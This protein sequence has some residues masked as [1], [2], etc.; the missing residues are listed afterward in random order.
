MWWSGWCVIRISKLDPK[1]KNH[2]ISTCVDNRILNN[3]FSPNVF[4]ISRS[5]FETRNRPYENT[6]SMARYNY[7]WITG[8]DAACRPKLV[9]RCGTAT[10]AG[11]T[12]GAWA[13]RLVTGRTDNVSRT[14][15]SDSQQLARL[16]GTA[17]LPVR[18]SDAATHISNHPSMFAALASRGRLQLLSFVEG[19]MRRTKSCGFRK[20]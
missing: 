8:A 13:W 16:A 19:H 14:S 6:T 17:P 15:K 9:H 3:F 12:P 7:T 4:Q 10:R 20:Q 5:T 2:A 18:L 11:A 1:M